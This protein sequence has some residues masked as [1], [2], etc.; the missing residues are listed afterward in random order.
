MKNVKLNGLEFILTHLFK[1]GVYVASVLYRG[2]QRFAN[3]F[4][5]VR[6][7]IFQKLIANG[8]EIRRQSFRHTQQSQIW[9]Q[10]K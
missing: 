2:V 4:R 7:R 6:R 8:G 9:L 10:N 1:N 3:T 5:N